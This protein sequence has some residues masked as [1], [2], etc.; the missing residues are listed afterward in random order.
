MHGK[1]LR[2]IKHAVCGSARSSRHQRSGRR[3]LRQ[4][5]PMNG[6][7][8]RI[9]GH[10]F[11]EYSCAVAPNPGAPLTMELG[12]TTPRVIAGSDRRAR[13][14]GAIS[15]L[16]G[17]RSSDQL[18]SSRCSIWTMKCGAGGTPPCSCCIT[19]VYHEGR[20]CTAMADCC[21]EGSPDEQSSAIQPSTQH[22]FVRLV[23][24]RAGQVV[25]AMSCARRAP[26][27]PITME[28]TRSV[29]RAS[30]RYSRFS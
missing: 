24:C 7:A 23:R 16:R 11:D 26:G 27:R 6:R 28:S 21:I 20:L 15:P 14:A 19:E 13:H 29:H 5:M 17:R 1:W 30:G 8:V 3:V 25:D 10:Q 18:T 12:M 2:N 22:E 9:N 4:Y